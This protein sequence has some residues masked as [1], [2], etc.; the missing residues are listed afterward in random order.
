MKIVGT[1][2]MV[3]GAFG[4]VAAVLSLFGPSLKA[5]G[6]DVVADVTSVPGALIGGALLLFAGAF[7]RRRAARL[8]NEPSRPAV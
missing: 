8:K 3:V 6:I 5:N 2:L 4:M 7:L 1:I